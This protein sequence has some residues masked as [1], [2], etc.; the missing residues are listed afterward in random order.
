MRATPP[1]R[2]TFI[3]YR[4]EDTKA[5][6]GRLHERLAAHFGKEHVFLDVDAIEPGRDFAERI[7]AFVSTCDV[8]IAM[9]GSKWVTT[10]DDSG[11]RRIDDPDDLVRLEIE[12]ALR[13]NVAVIPVL[14]EQ[15]ERLD[16]D[17]VPASLQELL[18]RQE[19]RLTHVEFQAQS[20]RL[21]ESIER[22]PGREMSKVLATALGFRWMRLVLRLDQEHHLTLDNTR[23][24]GRIYFDSALLYKSRLGIAGEHTFPV[25]YGGRA[26]AASLSVKTDGFGNLAHVLLVADRTVLYDSSSDA[27]EQLPPWRLH[28]AVTQ[29]SPLGFSRMALRLQLRSEHMIEINQTIGDWFGRLY[30]DGAL[31]LREWN[32]V[33]E[34]SFVINDVNRPVKVF[35]AIDMGPRNNIRKVVLT[36]DGA[37]AYE[38]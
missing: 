29:A 13:S 27:S 1:P 33:G 32:I 11:R 6:A 7:K 37:I 24:T 16:A 22:L 28:G 10:T 38:S 5:E 3:S 35:I 31:A 14:V 4:R 34:H 17:Q 8:L 23:W 15:A 20:R 25:Q 30:V 21:I 9:I 36:I 18:R 2:K 12:T 19:A 26:V